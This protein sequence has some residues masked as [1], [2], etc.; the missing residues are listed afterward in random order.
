MIGRDKIVNAVLMGQ[1]VRVVDPAC[2]TGGFLV[3]LMKDALALLKRRHE[4]NELTRAQL[5]TAIERVKKQTFYGADANA[6]VASAA[7]MNMI[8]AGDGQSNIH[9]AD[10]LS[11]TST[12]W[13]VNAPSCDIIM[14]NPPF[15]TSES[16]SLSASDLAQFPL[17]TKKGQLLFL[18]KM[19]LSARIG[20]DICT[21]IDDG[22]L[23]TDAAASLRRWL[24][25]HCRVMAVVSLP[26]IT[27]KPNKINVQSSI[28]YLRRRDLVDVDLEA[29]DS[30]NFVEVAELGYNG[31]GDPLR[32]F[33]EQ[34]LIDGIAR[35]LV[36]A[37]AADHGAGWRSF[38]VGTQAIAKDI[39]HRLD[40]RYWN[41][42]VVAG[43]AEL[44][45]TA[46]PNL[47]D[48]AVE[49]VR[50]GRSPSADAYVDE[51][52]GYALVVK[53]GSN[54]SRFGEVLRRGDF[55]EKNIFEDFTTDAKIQNGDVLLSSTGSGTLGKCAVY[56]SDE[57]AVADGHV[58]IIRLD[59]NLH[60]PEYVCD[61]L[62]LGFGAAQVERLYTGSTG[63]IEITAEQVKSITIELPGDVATQATVSDEWRK[64]ENDYRHALDAAERAFASNSA[65]FLSVAPLTSHSLGDSSGAGEEDAAF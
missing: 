26:P 30:I 2:G 42:D 18:Q 21:V 6:S 56:R 37:D 20:C 23:N 1:D 44:R 61:Y 55:I 41:S 19:V 48:M 15:G 64:I 27:F 46:A 28:L 58:T 8:V 63:L 25:Q 34:A 31:A 53:A 9:A 43:L 47:G 33:N 51:A 62:R 13:S 52:D 17:K 50:R 24:L 59:A 29:D 5:S 65:R 4:R 38:A 39:G 57:P 22:V 11:A 10:T 45:A 3:Y 12:L 35:H 7:K 16:V 49:P 60:H 32:G 36:D 14:T 54:I 40:P